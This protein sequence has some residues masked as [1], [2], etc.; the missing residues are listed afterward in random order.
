MF[1]QRIIVKVTGVP[2]DYLVDI[3]PELYGPCTVFKSGKKVLHLQVLQALCG[4]LIAAL[5]WF[6][7]FR[8]DLATEKF[9]FNPCNP[10]VGNKIVNGK[11][12]TV[13]FHVDDLMSSHMN[14]KIS[15]DFKKWLN[16]KYESYG[17]VKVTRGKIH[18]YL[19]IR[20]DFRKKAK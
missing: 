12:Q 3:A 13:R 20:F 9:E 17:V 2:V 19:G 16:E 4:M 8:K 10:C 5:L 14:P 7:Q 6:D 15:D 1:P 11:Q 18:D